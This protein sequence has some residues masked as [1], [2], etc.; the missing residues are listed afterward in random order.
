MFSPFGKGTLL[1]GTQLDYTCITK[2]YT[3]ISFIEDYSKQILFSKLLRYYF[4]RGSVVKSTLA[5]TCLTMNAREQPA[6]NVEFR[7]IVCLLFQN[8]IKTCHLKLK[9]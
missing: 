2:L 3:A 1:L 8:Q 5:I 6:R 7:F 9:L 4:K